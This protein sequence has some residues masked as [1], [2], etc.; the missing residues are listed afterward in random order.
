MKVLF[1]FIIFFAILNA[2]AA[3]SDVI[4]LQDK[5]TDEL[6]LVKN[7]VLEKAQEKPSDD[8]LSEVDSD[9]SLPDWVVAEVRG[10]GSLMVLRGGAAV[11]VQTFG[12][13]LEAG[14]DSGIMFVMAGTDGAFVP[15]LGA[16]VKLRLTPQ[17]NKTIYFRG[18]VYKPFNISSDNL[19]Y[20]VGVGME[21]EGGVFIELTLD[22]FQNDE[23][24][25]F[26]FPF[27]TFG[28]KFGGAEKAQEESIFAEDDE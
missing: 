4:L 17:K 26:I 2:F 16:Y 23:G 6:V 8:E 19:N 13:H 3:D 28:Q 10:G 11:G 18:R 12:G 20:S 21:R 9:F 1:G 15:E 5:E 25:S 7:G 24:D 22:R 14:V 27:F